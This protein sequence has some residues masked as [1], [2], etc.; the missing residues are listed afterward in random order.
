M[1]VES[2]KYNIEGFAQYDML[3]CQQKQQ[4]QK[5]QDDNTDDDDELDLAYIE[6]DEIHE[7]NKPYTFYSR[8]FIGKVLN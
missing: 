5:K 8:F 6:S 7:T 1:I 3:N 4:K 2:E